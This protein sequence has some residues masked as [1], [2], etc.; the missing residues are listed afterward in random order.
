MGASGSKPRLGL[1]GRYG[2]VGHRRGAAAPL[3]QVKELED[4]SRRRELVDE[5]SLDSESRAALEADD[6]VIF[7][8]ASVEQFDEDEPS[9]MLTMEALAKALPQLFEDGIISRRHKDIKVGEVL[10]EYTLEEPTEMQVGD[11]T[12]AFDA[13][14]TLETQVVEEG[15][16]HPGGDDVAQD[17]EFWIVANL[18]ANSEIAKETRLRALSGDLDG[19]SVT[20]YAKEWR[21]TD[22][23][24]VVTDLDWHAVT[25]GEE[26]KIKN[27]DSRFGVAEFKA[28]FSERVTDLFGGSATNDGGTDASGLAEQIHHKANDTMSHEFNGQLFRK[29]GKEMGFDET[30]LQAAATLQSKA[31]P[32]DEEGYR[33]KAEAIASEHDLDADRL[34][35]TAKALSGS[36]NPKMGEDMMAILDEVENQIGEEAA[37]AIRM[38]LEAGEDDE[39]DDPEEGEMK[40]D[41][42]DEEGE[43]EDHDMEDEEHDEEDEKEETADDTPDLPEGVVTEEKLDERLEELKAGMV[44]EEQITS[45]K[46]DLEETTK[47]AINESLPGI[48]EDVGEKMATGSTSDPASGSTQDAVDYTND[49]QGAFGASGGD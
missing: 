9:Q 22:D 7:G 48:V 4:G 36:E 45:L 10:P 12:V 44:S 28:A 39:S 26:H 2:I 6:F 37:S 40:E 41:E 18:K 34:V 38:A 42:E 14:E 31:D 11:E 20:I 8:R 33:E 13:G 43:D 49:I 1:S 5:E 21:D 29:A 32:D 19:F 35:T 25:I 47:A 23:G 15:D 30:I 27:K 17:D 16:P 46:E 3:G 24:Q